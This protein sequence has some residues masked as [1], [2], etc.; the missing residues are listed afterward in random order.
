[1]SKGTW[2]GQTG[3]ELIRRNCM[4]HMVGFKRNFRFETSE[5]DQNKTWFMI[6]YRVVDSFFKDTIILLKKIL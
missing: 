6:E 5:Y 4:G 2:K 1:M 3:E